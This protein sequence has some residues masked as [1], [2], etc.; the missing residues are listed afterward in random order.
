MSVLEEEIEEALASAPAGEAEIYTVQL[1]HASFAEPIR[2]ARW[3]E[4]ISLP[5]NFGDAPVLFKAIPFTIVPG[6]EG[7]DGPKPWRLSIGNPAF[8]VPYLRAAAAS[9]S[10]FQVTFRAYTTTDL[11]QPGDIVDGLILRQVDL[12]VTEAEAALDTPAIEDQAFPLRVYDA[13]L[14]PTLQNAAI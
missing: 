5:P 4:D 10:P 12:S 1:D 3:P 13:T 11:T 9:S 2:A 7:P 14:Y 8:L 6:S